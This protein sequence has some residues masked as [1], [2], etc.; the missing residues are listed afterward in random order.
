[1]GGPIRIGSSL[2]HMEQARLPAG[3]GFAHRVGMIVRDVVHTLVCF[4]QGRGKHKRHKHT[5]S[6]E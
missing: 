3:R 2:G 1:M 4:N 5:G 6:Y